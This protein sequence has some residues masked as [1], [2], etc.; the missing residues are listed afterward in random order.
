LGLWA[1]CLQSRCSVIWVTSPVHFVVVILEM[2]SQE[3]FA[4]AGLK[5]Q[6]W[7]QPPE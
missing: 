6:S 7:S 4:W 1:L 5:P 2:E 3:L